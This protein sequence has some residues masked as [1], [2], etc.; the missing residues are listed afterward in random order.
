MILITRHHRV[1]FTLIELLITISIIIL[2]VSVLTV[3]LVSARTSAQVAETQ[4]RLTALRSATVRFKEDIGYYPAVL[5]AQRSLLPLPNVDIPTDYRADAQEWYS[6]TSPAEYLIGY[7][8]RSYD[9]FGRL[10]GAPSNGPSFPEMPKLGIRHPGMDGVWRATHTFANQSDDGVAMVSDRNP[11]TN[12]K[13]YGPYLEVE[14]EQMFGRLAFEPGVSQ[15]MVDPVTGKTKIFYPGDAGYDTNQPMVIVD[16]WGTPIRYYRTV[17]P[18]PFDLTKPHMSIAKTY[19]PSNSYDRPT[20]SDYVVLRPFEFE[21]GK[22]IDGSL[23]DFRD[24]TS[25]STGDTSTTMELQTGQ[26]AYFSAGPD[27]QSNEY[28]RADVLGLDGNVDF[29]TDETNADNIIEV[30][31]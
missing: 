26:F 28:I 20:M 31:P 27:E 29:P 15:P 5:D 8:D 7:E 10:P 24:G 9:G 30:G 3:A 23:A 16:S 1:G 21:E 14:N 12:G 22:V 4:S 11:F 2:L 17:Y 19:P 6:I 25:Q 13:V 18:L